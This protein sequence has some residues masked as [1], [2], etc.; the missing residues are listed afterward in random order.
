MEQIIYWLQQQSGFNK[1]HMLVEQNIYF[2]KQSIYLFEEITYILSLVVPNSYFNLQ[3][4]NITKQDT[5]WW[6]S[7]IMRM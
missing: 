6:K 7:S 3:Q 4:A 5:H 1:L 2:V